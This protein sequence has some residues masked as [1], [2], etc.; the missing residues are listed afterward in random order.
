MEQYTTL[1]MIENAQQAMHDALAE[2]ERQSARQFETLLNRV[3]DLEEQ[4]KVLEKKCEDRD[5]VVT[6][7]IADNQ[8]EILKLQ[9]I[10][11]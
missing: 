11:K 5:V 2:M 1:D 3:S 8:V 10:R 9:R 6:R 4:V 7:A